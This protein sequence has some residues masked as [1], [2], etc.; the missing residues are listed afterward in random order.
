MPTRDY[1]TLITALQDEYRAY[2][3]ASG[4]VQARA[5]RV[6]VD[7]G[8]HTLR[9][10]QPFPP[11]I[12][13]AAGA[14]VEDADGHHILDFWQG[15]YA[16]IL[17]H[18]PTVVTEALAAFFADG[19]GLQTGFVEET[20]ADLAALIC[21][22]AGLERIRFTTA[23]TLATMNAILLARAHT[24]REL[25]LKVG[26]GWHGGHLWGLK[27]VGHRAQGFGGVDSSGV[28]A[29]L[30]R[31]TIVTTFNDPQRLE[32]DFRENAGCLACFILEPVIGAGG[33]IP[34]S[35]E[36]LQTARRL[37]DQHGV[38]LIFDE[39]ISGFRYRAGDVG[40]L[41]GIRPDLITLGKIIGGGMPVAAVGG[42]AEIMD[43]AGRAGGR[44]VKFSGGT[45]SG[46]PA[47]MLAAK[48]LLQYLVD[49]EDEVYPFLAD[50]SRTLQEKV[51]AVFRQAGWPAAFAGAESDI[52]PDNSLKMLVFPYEEIGPL[53]RPE[54]VLNPEEVDVALAETV[55]KMAML[56]QDVHIVHGLGALSTAHTEA[57]IDRLCVA[58]AGVVA[59]ISPFI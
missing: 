51:L 16:N 26:G 23:G 37:C 30:A 3:P 22:Q 42:R 39:V 14:Y 25:V 55:L 21:R 4:E 20:Q 34:A 50:L 28:P 33:M 54:Q 6:L 56:L 41:Y 35:R 24:G 46:H 57:D 59:R 18:N 9:L 38:V 58:F 5:A 52:L 17:G 27:G 10:I 15:H 7:G 31:D 12:H 43:Q 45:Y 53:T 1:T 8:S 47:S 49:H 19:H 32:E 44:K 40:L 11:R 13:R 48:V 29:E 2:A 36:Y